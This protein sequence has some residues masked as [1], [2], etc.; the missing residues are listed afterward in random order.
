MEGGLRS[1]GTPPEG[2]AEANGIGF[3][4]N[5]LVSELIMHGHAVI[6]KV[7]GKEYE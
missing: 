3:L 6:I 4:P 5:I 7:L 2:F 1:N